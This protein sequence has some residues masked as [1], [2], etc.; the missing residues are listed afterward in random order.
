MTKQEFI[1]NQDPKQI[2]EICEDRIMEQSKKTSKE[3]IK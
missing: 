3:L 1:H 2:K